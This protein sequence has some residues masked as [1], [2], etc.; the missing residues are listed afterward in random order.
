MIESGQDFNTVRL[1]LSFRSTQSV[2][3]AV[4]QVFSVPENS[5]GLSAGGD[6]VIHQSSR[7]GHPGTVD[8][9]DMIAAEKQEKDEDWTAPFDATPESAPSAILARRV[10]HQISQIVGRETIIEKGN[11]K[12]VWE[13]NRECYHCAGSHPE[14]CKTYSESPNVTGVSGGGDDGNDTREPTYSNAPAISRCS[15]SAASR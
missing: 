7:I 5:R 13:N 4:D 8:V 15:S 9:W 1:P 11:W 12:L 14:L 6:P 10:A 3:A 2:L